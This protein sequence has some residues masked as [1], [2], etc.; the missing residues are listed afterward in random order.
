M[1]KMG[2]KTGR[3]TPQ[4]VSHQLWEASLQGWTKDEDLIVA[5]KDFDTWLYHCGFKSWATRDAHRRSMKAL[6]YIDYD[7]TRP[8]RLGKTLTVFKEQRNGGLLAANEIGS[9]KERV[10]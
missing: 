8:G 6:G 1:T 3:S 5:F 10:S 2:P 7:D 4:E 9:T